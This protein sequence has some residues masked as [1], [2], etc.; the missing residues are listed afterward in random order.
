MMIK[1][2]N[3]VNNIYNNLDMEFNKDNN[4]EII[5]TNTYHR[6]KLSNSSIILIKVL[7]LFNKG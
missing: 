2:V 6:R 4:T 1:S 3:R 5:K 7:P